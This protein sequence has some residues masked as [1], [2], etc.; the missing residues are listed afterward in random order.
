MVGL[1]HWKFYEG[2]W[3]LLNWAEI[4]GLVFNLQC[5]I[6]KLRKNVNLKEMRVVQRNL[7][8]SWEVRLLAVRKVTQ[9]NRGKR[10][11][12][13]DGIKVTTGEERMRLTCKLVFDGS[14]DRIRRI[15]IPKSIVK[16]KPLSIPTIKNRA[17]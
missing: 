14:T 2:D 10:T 7:T 6:Y 1:Q 17:Q 4:E 8:D 5:I 9:D 3:K 16:V 15:Y 11:C 12:G 13:V